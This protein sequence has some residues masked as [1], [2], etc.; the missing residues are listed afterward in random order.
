MIKEQL[1]ILPALESDMPVIEQIAK[2][3]DLDRE[4]MKGSQFV[5][6]K[7]EKNIIGIGRLRNYPKQTGWSEIATVAVIEEER[8]KGIGSLIMNELIGRAPSE[9]FVTCVIPDFFTRFGFQKIKQYPPVLEK[10]VDFCKSYDFR[11]D[12][13]F[14]MKLQK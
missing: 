5:V 12:Q 14:V 11:D 7:K 3:F 2:K 13:I 6:A 8:K 4:D 10:K 1:K 9:I